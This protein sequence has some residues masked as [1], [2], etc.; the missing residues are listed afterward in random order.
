MRP[1]VTINHFRF[2]D[3]I[4]NDIDHSGNRLPGV[5]NFVGN[6][7]LYGKLQGGL[8]ALVNHRLIGRMPMNDANS[9]FTEPYQLTEFTLG[10]ENDIS[11][12]FFVDAF[13]SARN[14]FDI[15]YPSMI[16]VNAPSFGNRPPR[17]YYPGNPVNFTTGIKVSYRFK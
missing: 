5:P 16:L 2:T 10:Y 15:S 8:Y 9:L 1:N 12:R 4:D 6:A 7:G 17:Y 3:F 14:I 13:V 11:N